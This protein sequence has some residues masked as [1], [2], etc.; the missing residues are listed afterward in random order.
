MCDVF[1]FSFF[2]VFFFCFEFFYF[3]FRFS[4]MRRCVLF[5]ILFFI[6]YLFIFCFLFFLMRVIFLCEVFYIFFDDYTTYPQLANMGRKRMPS[7]HRFFNARTALVSIR[8]NHFA[9]SFGMQHECLIPVIWALD[10]QVRYSL[11]IF[12]HNPRSDR[13]VYRTTRTSTTRTHKPVLGQRTPG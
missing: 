9:E 2:L 1:I 6:F 8:R 5:C 13:Q 12:F 11:G 7:A 4:V 10:S 3:V